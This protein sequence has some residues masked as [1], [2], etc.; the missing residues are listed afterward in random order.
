MTDPAAQLKSA[1]AGLAASLPRG[2]HLTEDEIAAY[3]AGTLPA[4]EAAW[5]Q[6]HLLACAECTDLL[7]GLDDLAGEGEPVP[8]GEV[9]AAWQQMRALLPAAEPAAVLP[10]PLPFPPPRRAAKPPVWL[11]ALA[12]SLLVAVVGLSLYTAS[13]RRMVSELSQP[14]STE[15]NELSPDSYRGGEEKALKVELAPGDRSFLLVLHATDSQTFSSYELEIARTGGAVVW[16]GDLR[17]DK[18]GPFIL[19]LPRSL[20]GEG[21]YFLRLWGERGKG[22]EILGEYGLKVVAHP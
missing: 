11:G 13:L 21:E 19:I 6:D 7:L 18:L 14:Q 5:A 10:A 3:H 2:P 4:A 15:L 17:R 16:H 20:V 8:A 9:A 1:M 22:R 12:A